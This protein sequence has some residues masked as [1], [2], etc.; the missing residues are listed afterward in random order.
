MNE[1]GYTCECGWFV[2]DV[3]VDLHDCVKKMPIAWK[4]VQVPTLY[5]ALPEM[6]D[7]AMLRARASGVKQKVLVVGGEDH[8]AVKTRMLMCQ[9]EDM[10][11]WRE[12]M[13][14]VSR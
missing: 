11:K 13:N 5:A 14:H 2:S 3:R 7:R 12:V 1:P 9:P 10:E 6:M 4:D 8:P